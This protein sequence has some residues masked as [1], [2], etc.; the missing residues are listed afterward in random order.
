MV[1]DL[2]A[3][4]SIAWYNAWRTRLSLNGF[5]PFTLEYSSSS[6][7]WS[8]P[9]KTI[10]FSVPSSTLMLESCFNRGTSCGGGSLTRSTSPDSRAATRVPSDTIGR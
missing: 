3:S 10:R 8:M 5:L 6:R 7:F 9:M 4:M 2:I 1:V